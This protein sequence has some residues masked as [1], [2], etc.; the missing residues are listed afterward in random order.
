MSGICNKMMRF[1]EDDHAQA[2]WLAFG[3]ALGIT[4]LI[5]LVRWRRGKGLDAL[6]DEPASVGT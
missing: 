3:T 4:L 1:I 2:F 5:E 6:D